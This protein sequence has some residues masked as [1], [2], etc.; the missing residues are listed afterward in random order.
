MVPVC[1][2]SYS[3]DAANAIENEMIYPARVSIRRPGGNPIR[4]FP[5]STR[6]M[7]TIEGDE[8]AEP[9]AEL[10]PCCTGAI[11]ASLQFNGRRML[12]LFKLCNDLPI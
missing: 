8:M 12:C 10:V 3:A 9:Q 7:I 5:A 1:G 11:N 6:K 2:V 4:R